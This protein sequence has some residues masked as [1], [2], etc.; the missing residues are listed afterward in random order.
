[1]LLIVAGLLALRKVEMSIFGML[2]LLHKV[3]TNICFT[4]IELKPVT[5]ALFLHKHISLFGL[6]GTWLLLNRVLLC[7][8]RLDRRQKRPMLLLLRIEVSPLALCISV[9]KHQLGL[10][11]NW[12]RTE[13]ELGVDWRYKPKVIE[14][15]LTQ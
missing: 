7:S 14:H 2:L 11:Q 3:V 5:F 15:V 1:M 13:V 12:F 9:R 4:Y 6:F 10:L 8:W